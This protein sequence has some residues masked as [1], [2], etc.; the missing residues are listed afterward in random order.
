MTGSQINLSSPNFINKEATKPESAYFAV[1]PPPNI[2]IKTAVIKAKHKDTT[3]IILLSDDNMLYE[4]FKNTEEKT[5]QHK[6]HIAIISIP[7]VFG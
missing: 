6:T 2:P 7:T 4:F 5:P 1:N 3:L